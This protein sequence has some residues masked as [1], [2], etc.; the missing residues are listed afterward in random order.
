MIV[1]FNSDKIKVNGPKVDG[2]WTLSFELGEYEQGEVA[3]LMTI[4]Q[5]K[6]IKLQVTDE[7]PEEL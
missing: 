4:R 1:N 5:G 3:K 6:I 7:E 2:T